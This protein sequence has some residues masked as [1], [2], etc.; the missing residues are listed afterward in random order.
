MPFSCAF[1]SFKHV[2][3]LS[4]VLGRKDLWTCGL[5]SRIKT[6]HPELLVL[7]REE[8]RMFPILRDRER[9]L[10]AWEVPHQAVDWLP[11]LLVTP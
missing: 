3:T 4:H 11:I 5:I 10:V 1:F 6:R 8:N 7:K 9:D 2:S